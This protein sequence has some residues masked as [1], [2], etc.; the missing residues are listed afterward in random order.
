M[1]VGNDFQRHFPVI[2]WT[3][4]GRLTGNILGI[5]FFGILDWK[6]FG[7]FSWHLSGDSTNNITH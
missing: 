4:P 5:S 1:R 3:G 2:H 6:D 7:F